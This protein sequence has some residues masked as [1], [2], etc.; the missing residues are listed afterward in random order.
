[1]KSPLSY[2]ILIVA[3]T[4]LPNLSH[5]Q[6]EPVAIFYQQSVGNSLESAVDLRRSISF[7]ARDQSPWNLHI[8]SPVA[9]EE[10]F[11]PA[12]TTTTITTKNNLYNYTVTPSHFP[13]STIELETTVELDPESMTI[14]YRGLKF[15]ISVLQLEITDTRFPTPAVDE[16]L[17]VGQAVTSLN[18]ENDCWCEPDRRHRP[19]P[20]SDC[21][22]VSVQS[23]PQTAYSDFRLPQNSRP[24][25]AGDNLQFHL[26]VV[27][28]CADAVKVKSESEPIPKG[29]FIC[30]ES[31]NACAKQAMQNDDGRPNNRRAGNHYCPNFACIKYT[32]GATTVNNNPGGPSSTE[33]KDSE[34]PPRDNSGPMGTPNLAYTIAKN[35][36]KTALFAGASLGVVIQEFIIWMVC[37]APSQRLENEGWWGCITRINNGETTLVSGIAGSGIS[38]VALG[39]LNDRRCY[40]RQRQA[41]EGLHHSTSTTRI[42]IQ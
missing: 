22:A 28:E 42:T 39:A 11:A 7:S 31:H 9:L 29:E 40:C 23:Q 21:P 20:R 4:L 34:D 35:R 18:P 25:L 10:G 27:D 15:P 37:T 33:G 32:G 8:I 36:I 16:L 6:S 24:Y 19:Y 2:R 3:A 13:T 30:L 14:E 41:E 26:Q 12:D 5:S 17:Q 1:M 38:L